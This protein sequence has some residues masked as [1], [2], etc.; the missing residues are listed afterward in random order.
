MTGGEI[1]RAWRREAGFS[2][3]KLAEAMARS[4][5][6]VIHVE[7]G[8]IWTTP[9]IAAEMADVFGKGII[10]PLLQAAFEGALERAGLTAEV[11]VIC[12]E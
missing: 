8:R 2:Q 10:Q 3:E 9:T 7:N 5:T 6:W 1:V 12:P 11:T 4:R